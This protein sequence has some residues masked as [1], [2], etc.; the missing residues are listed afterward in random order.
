MVGDEA[1]SI[2]KAAVS[3]VQEQGRPRDGARVPAGQ[4][5]TTV[6]LHEHQRRAEFPSHVVALELAS[7]LL[8]TR[9]HRG[10]PV[11]TCLQLVEG[12]GLVGEAPSEPSQPLLLVQ[13]EA[14]GPHAVEVVGKRAFEEGGAALLCGGSLSDELLYLPSL[15]A[16]FFSPFV[17]SIY[18]NCVTYTRNHHFYGDAL[19]PCAA[20]RPLPFPGIPPPVMGRVR[21]PSDPSLIFDPAS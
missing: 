8:T 14:E 4:Q 10:V 12:E 7:L 6:P 19:A 9:R 21:P 11:E 17:G 2:L 18:S 13:H 20:A 15:I 3:A 1:L 5:P 16:H